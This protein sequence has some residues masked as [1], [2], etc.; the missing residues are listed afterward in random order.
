MT[1]QRRDL[2]I[3]DPLTRELNQWSETEQVPRLWLRDD[4][5][6]TVGPKLKQFA[7]LTAEFAIPTVLAVIPE[8]TQDD[9][10]SF[11]RTQPHLH[12]A[13]HGFSHTNH[14]LPGEKKCEFPD[15]R[16]ASVMHLELVR[17]HANIR[18]MFGAHTI[19]MFVPPWNRLG[20]NAAKLLCKTDF[21][22]V[23]GYGPKH[24]QVEP[25]SPPQI[26]THVDIIDWSAPRVGA[27]RVTIPP[28]DL[29][30]RLANALEQARTSRL[31]IIGLLT[32]HAVHET[33]A[34]T[35]LEQLFNFIASDGRA[36]WTLPAP[37]SVVTKFD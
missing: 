19:D 15:H 14:A 24:W 34:H 31:G 29:V 37:S 1:T 2:S 25:Q 8:C 6:V 23:S 20:Q 36:I 30:I 16:D 35:F 4:D 13:T 10:P 32:H 21:N 17:G 5:A 28:Q 9:L 22:L 12:A 26:N 18:D 11:I 3:W 7:A 27:T 33:F